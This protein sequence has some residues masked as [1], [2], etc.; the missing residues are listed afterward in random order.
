MVGAR[1]RERL[2]ESLGAV[3]VTLDADDLVRIEKAIPA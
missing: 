3:E 2:A 1:R